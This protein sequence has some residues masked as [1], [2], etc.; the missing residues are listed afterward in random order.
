GHS[1]PQ[2]RN[3]PDTS[4]K[5]TNAN[6]FT[7]PFQSKY[8]FTPLQN[9]DVETDKDG[10]STNDNTQDSQVSP[11]IPSIYVYNISNYETFHTSL[12][13]Q[14]FDDFSITHT[15]NSLKLNPSSIEDYRSKTKSFD[16]TEIQYH[17]YQFTTEKQL[18]V[19]IRNS[20]I[21]ITEEM[22]F[23]E[24]KEL[25]FDIDTIVTLRS[26]VEPRKPSTGIPQCCQRSSHTKKFCHLPPRCVKCASDHH[27]TQCQ[28]ILETPAKCVN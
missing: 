25:N 5:R 21:P 2:T 6:P 7:P 3:L 10:V 26:L 1:S 22:I 24:L 16:E 19:V 4:R 18:S 17:T 8:K 27:F 23:N 12:S 20:S 15:K 13:N 28:K 11:K 9:I 14:A